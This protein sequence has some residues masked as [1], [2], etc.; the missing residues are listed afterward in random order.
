[1]IKLVFT[2]GR[3]TILFTIKDK[4]IYY[5]DRRFQ[6][7]IKIMPKDKEFDVKIIMSRNRIPKEII[8]LVRE[9]NSGKN[10]EEYQNAPNDNELSKIII[11]DAK[12][13][14]CVLQKEIIEDSKSEG[15]NN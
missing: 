14:G 11:R 5:L 3:E 1:M 2:I 7:G 6:E 4:N 10:L 9:S 15:G 13:K 12:T 8:E